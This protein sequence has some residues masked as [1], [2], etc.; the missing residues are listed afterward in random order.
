MSPFI[1]FSVPL[2]LCVEKSFGF[3]P[4]LKVG[5]TLVVI[6]MGGEGFE[7]FGI[8]RV[9]LFRQRLEFFE[10]AYHCPGVAVMALQKVIPIVV[11]LGL[12][13]LGMRG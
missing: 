5:D 9:I 8:A 1:L 12:L 7:E 2:F 13:T 11:G 4:F 6:R 3:S 10:E